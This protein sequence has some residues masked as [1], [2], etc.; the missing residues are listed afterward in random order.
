MTDKIKI[1]DRKYL[2]E[3]YAEL[4][5]REY[6]YDDE[7]ENMYDKDKWTYQLMTEPYHLFENYIIEGEN[8]SDEDLIEWRKENLY[9]PPFGTPDEDLIEWRKSNL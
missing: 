3:E 1:S 4:D 9:H 7:L 6:I 2:S 5:H 8:D